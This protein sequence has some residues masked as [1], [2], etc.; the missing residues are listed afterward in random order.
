VSRLLVEVNATGQTTARP[1]LSWLARE[2]VR[3][4]FVQEKAAWSY[5]RA[6]NAPQRIAPLPELPTAL[7]GFNVRLVLSGTLTHQLVV[8]DPA[9]PIQDTEAMLAWARHQFVHYH[10]P[11][12]QRWPLA[13]WQNRAQ[14][15][16]SAAH[17]I[18]L[19]ALLRAAESQR[20]HLRAV[21]PWWA[22]ALQA[23]TLEAPTLALAERAELWLVE[24]PQVTRLVCGSGRLLQIERH[25]LEQANVTALGALVADHGGDTTARWLL[26]YG[27]DET[28]IGELPLRRLGSLGADHPLA[29]WVGS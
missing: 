21:Q 2:P 25:W 4:L 10:G 16:V 6:A 24:G 3:T 20:V 18:D 9:L 17:G 28:G 5:E 29:R 1:R 11:A 13:A 14:R 23:A 8:S 19:D 26:G 27:I 7:A 12:A 15:G 22:V